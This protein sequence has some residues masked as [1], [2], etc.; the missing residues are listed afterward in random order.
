M[1]AAPIQLERE[2]DVF[3]MSMTADENRW[4][5]TFV[6]AFNAALDEIELSTDP[7]AMIT[8][9]VDEKFFSNGLDLE[10]MAA[11]GEH[12]GGDRDAFGS[13]YMALCARL[14]TFP[15][16]TVAA[17][18]GHAFGAGF[19]IA[20]CHDLRIMR[21]DRGYLCANEVEIGMTIPEPELALFRHKIPMGAFHE[22]VVLARRWTGPAAKDAGFVHATTSLEN[23]RPVALQ[24]AER[25][26]GVAKNREVLGWM[27]ERL[28]G[29]RA[30][31]NESHGA[32]HMLRN[33]AEFSRARRPER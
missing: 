14:I 22:T 23:V 4:N 16:P 29:E 30:A 17:V 20:L 2:G 7:V 11:Q 28:Y 3:V 8:A 21:E 24:T 27:K 5:T 18:N 12:P 26:L 15:V 32:A 31:I 33:P 25:Q 1:T 9:S 19:M 10:W 13:E 6:R